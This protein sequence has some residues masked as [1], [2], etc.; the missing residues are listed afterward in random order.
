MPKNDA[1]VLADSEAAEE[2]VAPGG[3]HPSP[4]RPVII[5]NHHQSSSLKDCHR[6]NCLLL[7]EPGSGSQGSRSGSGEPLLHPPLGPGDEEDGV[8]SS[9]ESGTGRGH[10]ASLLT[11]PLQTGQDSYGL[12]YGGSYRE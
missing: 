8:P 3:G 11:P 10:L 4:G 5:H 2:E 6:A 1:Q 9:A 12:A 7:P